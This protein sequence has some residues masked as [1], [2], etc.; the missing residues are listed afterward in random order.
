[1]RFSRAILMSL[2]VLL[3]LGIA[4]GAEAQGNRPYHNGSVWEL[5]FIRMNAGME[6]EYLA[7][8]ADEWKRER[9]IMQQDNQIISYKVMQTEAHDASDY[10]LILMTEYKDLATLEASQKKEDAVNEQAVGSVEQQRQGY[11]DRQ[12]IRHI[13]GSRVARQIVLESKPAE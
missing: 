4:A 2:S 11:R 9:E 3:G 8:V 7:Y 5:E 10:N 12:Q 6:A 1:M 13:L